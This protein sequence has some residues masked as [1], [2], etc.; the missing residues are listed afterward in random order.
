MDVFATLDGQGFVW[1]SEKALK[2]LLK[3]GVAFDEAR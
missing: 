2:N 1:D 3:H